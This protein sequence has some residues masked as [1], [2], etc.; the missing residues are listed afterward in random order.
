MF[1]GPIAMQILFKIFVPVNSL[2][3]ETY[4]QASWEFISIIMNIL[5]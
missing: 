2:K 3:R 5:T 1:P 4:A